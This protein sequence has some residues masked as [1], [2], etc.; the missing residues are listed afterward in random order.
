MTWHGDLPVERLVYNGEIMVEI[1]MKRDGFDDL[2]A[3]EF[4]MEEVINKY[5]GLGTPI[6]MWPA[7]LH[8][9]REYM[10]DYD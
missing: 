1:L 5:M 9:I 10:N 8:D 6:V 2:E 4:L 3:R 7:E